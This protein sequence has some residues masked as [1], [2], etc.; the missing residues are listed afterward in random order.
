MI[1]AESDTRTG[2]P[3]RRSPWRWIFFAFWLA[4]GGFFLWRSWDESLERDPDGQFGAFLWTGLLDWAPAIGVALLVLAA[5]GLIMS[6]EAWLLERSA[7]PK[8][9]ITPLLLLRRHPLHVVMCAGLL[10]LTAW[11][12]L[13]DSSLGLIGMGGAI[14]AFVTLARRLG[15]EPPNDPAAPHNRGKA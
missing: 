8:E 12:F 1:R 3:S 2:S 10:A 7:P 4:Y 6:F 15:L 11:G 5:I 13:N 14:W 9:P